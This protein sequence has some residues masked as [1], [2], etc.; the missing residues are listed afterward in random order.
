MCHESHDMENVTTGLGI[1]AAC[2]AVSGR[3]YAM[4]ACK[5]L[6]RLLGHTSS[7]CATLL[8]ALCNEHCNANPCPCQSD[9]ERE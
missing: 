5:I 1:E 2:H 8:D 7:C 6:L 9:I 4:Q 3:N